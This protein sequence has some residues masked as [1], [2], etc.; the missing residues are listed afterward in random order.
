M[1]GKKGSLTPAPIRA[2][3]SVFNVTQGPLGKEMIHSV[4]WRLG[5]LFLVYR[6]LRGQVDCC[7]YAVYSMCMCLGHRILGNKYGELYTV[8]KYIQKH[9][10]VLY[11]ILN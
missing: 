2:E 4:R 11:S 5:V 3:N 7:L 1:V 10:F 9:L 8:E 6:C